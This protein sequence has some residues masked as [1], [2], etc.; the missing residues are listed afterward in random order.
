MFW[1]TRL[2]S[3]VP[4][5]QHERNTSTKRSIRR[6]LGTLWGREEM[7]LEQLLFSFLCGHVRPCC[8]LGLA[9]QALFPSC[10]DY[11][12]YI[13]TMIHGFHVREFS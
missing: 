3:D 5:T 2:G 1:G 11:L 4:Q 6:G 7:L 10:L 8:L 13:S 9:L 12:S